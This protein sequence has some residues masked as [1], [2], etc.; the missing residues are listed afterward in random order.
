MILDIIL[1]LTRLS[2]RMIF[3]S[4]FFSF[5]YSYACRWSHPRT[6]F[7][8][9]IRTLS[10][11]LWNWNN[12]KIGVAFS[13]CNSF[14]FWMKRIIIIL[15]TSFFFARVFVFVPLV[16]NAHRTPLINRTIQ[17]FDKTENENTN[18]TGGR[19][20]FNSFIPLLHK[21][22][23]TAA[24]RFRA[25]RMDCIYALVHSATPHSVWTVK[26]DVLRTSMYYNT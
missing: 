3:L 10:R 26:N 16:E 13:E 1:M 4:F 14:E 11:C 23:V 19:W 20:F 25:S 21:F 7:I 18:N 15:S 8:H 6:F 17:L 9:L 2:I 22:F 24:L 5:F 12:N